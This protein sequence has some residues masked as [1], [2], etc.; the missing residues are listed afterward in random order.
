MILP[1]ESWGNHFSSNLDSQCRTFNKN[2]GFCLAMGSFIP[3]GNLFGP[4]S[5][6]ENIA[7]S[8]KTA[9]RPFPTRNTAPCSQPPTGVFGVSSYSSGCCVGD[10]YIHIIIANNGAQA[11][12]YLP[13][14]LCGKM[15]PNLPGLAIKFQPTNLF[16]K[17]T[18]LISQRLSR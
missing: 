10:T 12:S 7:A 3:I 4:A 9:T 1:Q 16:K 11:T 8:P 14:I 13:L 6:A 15:P 18:Y 5:C 2:C 17:F